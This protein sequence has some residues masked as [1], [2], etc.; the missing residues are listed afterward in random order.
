[1]NARQAQLQARTQRR[2]AAFALGR[3]VGV[4]GAVGA[5]DA[6]F[7]AP[8][9]LALSRDELVELVLRQSPSVQAAEANANAAE[10]STRAARAQYLPTI[11][12]SGGYD[13]SNNEF[14]FGTGR[15]GWSM[16][17]GLSYP[18]FN[19]FQREDAVGRAGIQAEVARLEL[20][21]ARRATRAQ[22]EQHLAAL[23]LAEQQIALTEE[24]VRVAEEDLRVQSERYRLGVSTILDQVS[25]QL[26]LVQAENDRIAA[27]H[28]YQIAKAELEALVGR[29]L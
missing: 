14:D 3:L 23:E 8:R 5:V 20:A 18:I 22:L 27:R 7:D 24:A 2:N 13:W 29:E 19:R 12:A 9:P 26:A 4:D 25:S 10:A 28:N 21:D 15:K 16:R 17:L 6:E 1:M 11:S